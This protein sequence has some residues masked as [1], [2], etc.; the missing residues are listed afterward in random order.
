MAPEDP[1]I[2]RDYEDARA[3][4]DAVLSDTYSRQAQYE[5]KSQE[6][7]AAAR[8]WK[9]VVAVRPNDGHCHERAAAAMTRAGEKLQEAAKLARRACEIEP[10]NLRYKLTLAEVYLAAGLTLNAKRE[11]EAAAQIS[12]QDGT[13]QTLLRRVNQGG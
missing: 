1:E 2:L 3:K 12:P 8:S 7:S 13:L 11:L 10:T 9:R 4:A 6:W 5:E